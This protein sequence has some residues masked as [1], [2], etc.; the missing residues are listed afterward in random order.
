MSETV[1]SGV[2][3]VV[4]PQNGTN[5][6]VPSNTRYAWNAPTGSNIGGGAA[7]S[8]QTTINGTL[9]NGVNVQR[10]ATYEVIPT[11]G[12]CTGVNAGAM[13]TVTVFVN[14][15][16]SITSPINRVICSG[17]TFE[18]SPTNVTSGIVPA[19]T[20]YSW[21][22]PTAAL[23]GVS[24]A[25]NAV[26]I[27]GTLSHGTNAPIVAVYNVVPQGPSNLGSCVG[28]TFVVNVTVNPIP[29]I[30]A[31]STTVCSGVTFAMTPVTGSN[32][33][34]ATNMRYSWTYIASSS[35]SLTGGVNGSSTVGNL[36]TGLLTNATNV[37][38]TATYNVVPIYSN[39]GVECSGL[40]FSATVFVNPRPSV[41][42]IAV[43][44][45]CTGSVFA[46]TPTSGIIPSNT[47]YGWGTPTQLGGGTIDGG[48][49]STFSSTNIFA[50]APLTNETNA[51]F[52]LRYTVTPQAGSCVGAQF[53]V[54]VTIDPKPFVPAL[55]TT[56][57]NGVF[58]VTPTPTTDGYNGVVPVNTVYN[59]SVPPTM[60]TA[61]MTSSGPNNATGNITGTLTNNTSVTQTAV[62]LVTP[63]FGAC[64]GLSS[65]EVFSLTVYVNPA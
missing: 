25:T 1:C 19:N 28:S 24:G 32:V 4:S 13:F 10:S 6:L 15:T 3:F 50:S 60:S 51:R 37:M 2:G 64:S 41:T 57:C 11:F 53:V 16:P 55:S 54:D 58:V 56:I 35:V 42:N 65:G 29:A 45:L 49:A 21:S 52:T 7:A 23:S 12:Q 20:T 62:Y 36:F 5:G 38:Q 40:A 39:G 8:N 18:V 44:P 61:S 34:A 31:L 63:S 17:S 22:V 48:A 30:N 27:S 59:W 46:V 43:G 47:V 26:S 14:P 9:T 33:P